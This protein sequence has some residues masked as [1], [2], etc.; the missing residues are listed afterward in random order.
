MLRWQKKGSQHYDIHPFHVCDRGRHNP[1]RVGHLRCAMIRGLRAI[2]PIVTQWIGAWY[3]GR[4]YLVAN[5][6]CGDAETS[7]PIGKGP[8]L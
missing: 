2:G 7:T 5:G 8:V 4:V 3:T 6:R 1:R